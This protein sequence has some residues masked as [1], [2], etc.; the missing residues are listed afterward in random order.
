MKT[1][2][3]FESDYTFMESCRVIPAEEVK[4]NPE[5]VREPKIE[6][7]TIKRRNSM[8]TFDEFFNME[9][10]YPNDSKDADKEVIKAAMTAAEARK[11]L[12]ESLFGKDNSASEELD[13]REQEIEELEEELDCE[14]KLEK[15]PDPAKEEIFATCL[16]FLHNHTEDEL[17]EIVRLA[18]K[19]A[20][21]FGY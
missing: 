19:A 8:K 16:N 21:V 17:Y 1:F 4:K 6:D 7:R 3:E 15:A 13:F 9:H 12:H 20:E 2:N 11:K 5:L 18:F 10:Q 14:V